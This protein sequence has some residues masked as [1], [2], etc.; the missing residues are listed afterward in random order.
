MNT[1]TRTIAW[2]LAMMGGLI[3]LRA[4]ETNLI[5]WHVVSSNRLTEIRQEFYALPRPVI[6]GWQTV[7]QRG[8]VMFFG[9]TAEMEGTNLV[10]TTNATAFIEDNIALT[11]N[12]FDG[13]VEISGALWP[14]LL[15]TNHSGEATAILLGLRNSPYSVEMDAFQN[16]GYCSPTNRGL[17]DVD[18]P[19]VRQ[20]LR[21]NLRR[22]LWL[23]AYGAPAAVPGGRI[24]SGSYGADFTNCTDEA[25]TPP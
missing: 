22:G 7:T 3:A 9:W 12:R 6:E 5:P 23:D 1:H 24:R 11:S 18:G 20:W 14:M 4:T 25:A 17:W 15:D 21:W 10:L 8:S 13:R 16:T 2:A 19:N